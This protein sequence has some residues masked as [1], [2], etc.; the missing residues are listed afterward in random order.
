MAG[1]RD[2]EGRYAMIYVPAG[3]PFR[4][5]LDKLRAERVKAWWFNP[6]SG[7]AS[8]IG[9][10]P[11]GGEREFTAPDAGE[12]LGWLLVLDD[13]APGLSP[14]GNSAVCRAVGSGLLLFLR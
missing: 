8:S 1:T 13:A 10:F 4:A 9:E 14:A 12:G 11:G 7:E 6:R 3:R 2:S 5:R